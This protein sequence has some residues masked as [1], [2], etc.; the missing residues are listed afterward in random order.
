[1]WDIGRDARRYDGPY[2]VIAHPPCARW[3]RLS[4]LV[5]ARWGY[6]QGNDDGCFLSALA[7]VRNF[8]GVLE[9]PA[10]SK[11]WK[12]YGLNKPPISGG[13]VNADFYGGFTCH[14]EQG[15]YG[16]RAKKAT[17]LYTF[18][19]YLPSLKWGHE[20]DSKSEALVSWCGNKTDRFYNRPR[21]SSK[22]A[23]ATP[24]KF[25][26]ELIKMALSVRRSQ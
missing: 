26:D 6:R 16:H 13:W 11:A 18:S 14:I 12:A 22:E 8:G 20:A 4:G 23:S 9:H 3:C 21:L 1:M 17:W 25:R 7:A 2:P 15:R 24:E 5:E 10:Y 19:T